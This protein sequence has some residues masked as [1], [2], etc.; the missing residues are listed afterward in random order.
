LPAE[1]LPDLFELH[2]GTF[3]V[4]LA[5][6]PDRRRVLEIIRDHRKPGRRLSGRR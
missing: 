4:Q 5:S 2:A 1:L 3:Y 6:E